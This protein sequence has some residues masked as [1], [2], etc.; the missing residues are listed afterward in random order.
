[1]V[2][3]NPSGFL[4][5]TIDG[6]TGRR[7]ATASPGKLVLSDDDLSSLWAFRSGS[8]FEIALSC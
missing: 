1:M 8:A 7:D 3:L 6:W 2:V 4:E 5:E